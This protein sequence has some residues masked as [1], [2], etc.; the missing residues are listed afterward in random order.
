[1]ERVFNVIFRT[2]TKEEITEGKP[3]QIPNSDY[4]P[5]ESDSDTGRKRLSARYPLLLP[6]QKE[7][8]PFEKKFFFF[9]WFQGLATACRHELNEPRFLRQE[10]WIESCR[11]GK[12]GKTRCPKNGVL[13]WSSRRP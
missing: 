7:L 3:V 2:F 12:T 13:E 6:T 10:Q 9:F 8:D 11:P 5:P 1:M 4:T